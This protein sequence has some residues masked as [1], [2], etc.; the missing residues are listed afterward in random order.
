M[1]MERRGGVVGAR[2]DGVVVVV[3]GIRILER[4]T[5]RTIVKLGRL[6][7]AEMYEWICCPGSSRGAGWYV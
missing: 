7:G 1:R 2:V 5:F 6:G 3:L 4:L